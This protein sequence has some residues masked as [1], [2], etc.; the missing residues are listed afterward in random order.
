MKDVTYL[1][2]IRKK[3]IKDFLVSR[4]GDEGL[5]LIEIL[6]KSKIFKGEK[7]ED[8]DFRRITRMVYRFDGKGWYDEKYEHIFTVSSRAG[9]V[10]KITDGEFDVGSMTWSPE[11]NHPIPAL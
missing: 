3:P 11:G 9:R 10:K 6:F 7:N 8:S 4:I 1:A 5:I 2:L